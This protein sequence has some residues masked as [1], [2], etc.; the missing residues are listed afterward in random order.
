MMETAGS[1]QDGLSLRFD[2]QRNVGLVYALSRYL[3]ATRLDPLTTQ[4]CS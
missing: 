4:A 1:D 3:L 2:P